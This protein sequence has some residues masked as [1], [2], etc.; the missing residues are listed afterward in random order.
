MF[1]RGVDHF[2]RFFT[3]E[4]QEQLYDYVRLCHL[5]TGH[6][7]RDKLF[8]H[9][10][11]LAYGISIEHVNH[12]LSACTTCIARRT[13]A[14]RRQITPII[15]KFSR[16]R[17]IIDLVDLRYY[18]DQNSGE[19]WLL[20]IMDS[21]T[22]YC[23]TSALKSKNS[24]DVIP[25]IRSVVLSLGEVFIIHT[26]NGLEFCNSRMTQLCEEFGIRHVR[27]RARC[28][29]IQ[30]QVERLNQTLKWMLSSTLLTNGNGFRWIDILENITY[31]YNTRIHSTTRFSPVHL[32]YGPRIREQMARGHTQALIEYIDSINQL[33]YNEEPRTEQI[34]Q[35]LHGLDVETN[36][37]EMDRLVVA[38]AAAEDLRDIAR[39]N[40]NSAA[41][42]MRRRS[43][44][45]NDILD[46]PLG[47]KVVI[48][49]DTDTNT[50]TRRRPFHE[51]LDCT[52]YTVVGILQHDRVQISSTN[53]L[54]NH[55]APT[56]SILID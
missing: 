3:V 41:E 53:M 26:D 39:R 9:M 1:K 56:R 35:E 27:G 12:V 43:N 49:T 34:Q 20:V 15:A 40:T 44:W 47:T 46:F 7:G 5:D 28:P 52:E 32:M 18:S 55:E 42:S 36:D 8:N 17:L 16:E 22:K 13:L 45:R 6:P 38:S 50:T 21:F 37:N 4:E 24:A 14:T 25:R 33:D 51:H 19:K 11:N 23:W 31:A 2:V 29:W 30:G 54:I 48:H 10:K